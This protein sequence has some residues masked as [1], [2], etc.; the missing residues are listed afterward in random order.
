MA[1]KKTNRIKKS[2]IDVALRLLLTGSLG[3]ALVAGNIACNQYSNIITQYLCG[4]GLNTDTEEAKAA[5]DSGNTLA[6]QVEA[7]GAVMLK[8]DGTLPLQKNKVNV[9]GWAGCDSGFITQGTGSGTGSRNDRVTL[10]GGLKE[11]G[12]SYNTDLTQKYE[13]LGYNRVTGGNY[14][15]EAYSDALY[16]QYYGVIEAPN[17]FY[18][19]E[20]MQSAKSYSDTAIVVIGRLMGE[21]NDYSKTQYIQNEEND[22]SRKL[23]ALS[24]REEYMLERVCKYFDNVVV[25]INSG[26]PMEAGFLENEKIGAGIFMGYPG[27]RGPIGVAKILTGE[28]NPSGHLSDTWAYDLSTAAS[29]ANAGREGTGSYTDI[30]GDTSL[31]TRANKY[32]DYAE[33]IYIGYKWYETADAEGFWDSSYAKQRWGILDG[34]DSVV[35]YPF[36]YGKSYTTFEW[37]ITDANVT[38]GMTVAKDGKIELTVAVKNT[39]SVAGK[40]VVQLYYSAP[41]TKGGIE[42]SAVNLG[43]FAKTAL[44]KPGEYESVKISL[45]VEDMKSYD[46]YDRNNNGFMGYEL[47]KGEYTISL[48]TDSH[49]LATTG[50][51]DGRNSY[52]VQV[53]DDIRYETDSTTGNKVENRFTNYTNAVSG[54]SSTIQEYAVSDAHSIDGND[55]DVKI[56]YMTRGDFTGTFPEEKIATRTA[57]QLKTDAFY[58]TPESKLSKNPDDVAPTFNS[59]ETSWTLTDVMGLDYEDEKWDELVSQLS[60]DTMASLIVHGGFGTISIPSIG[61]PS[62]VDADG[63]SGFNNAVTG[64][65]NLKAVNYPCDTIIGSTWD[66]YM[67]YQVGRAIGIEA[68]A[69]GLNGIYGPGNNLHRSAMGGRNFEYYSEDA[70]LSGI[71]CAYEVYGMKEQG[72]TA[73]VKHIAAN[74]TESGRNGAFKW[75]T[76]QSMRENYLKAFEILVKVGKSNA[77]M[78]SVDRVGSTRAS[79]SWAMLTGIMRNE[80]GFRG[81]V[82]T[83]YY[84]NAGKSRETDTIHDVDEC[85]RAGNSQLLWT[86]GGIGFFNDA[87]SAT[88]KK[89]I[90]K[91]AKDILFAYVDTKNFAATAQGLE[92]DSMIGESVEVFAW[93]KPV[94]LG[95]DVVGGL[96]I[97]LSVVTAFKPKKVKEKKVKKAAKKD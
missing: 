85:V 35:Q 63:P 55:E 24:Q 13:A 25:L 96:L 56:K 68:D 60:L 28:V 20:L 34:Y 33:D 90:F 46:C 77:M 88:A 16:K 53:S 22:A 32:N 76:E 70:V 71:M 94:L 57:G 15:I 69:I 30:S 43:A 61:K 8:N 54:A 89:A 75:L 72:L 79:S 91:S 21:G 73:Y 84:Q 52:T 97:L 14:V 78:T 47:E 41:Y 59:T 86:D 58:V 48:R 7:E 65:G 1:K 92:K 23:Q 18:S 10:L 3:F 5:R 38:D 82:I 42:K 9:F 11:V 93:W 83:D 81:T 66:W 40:D 95:V 12:L 37:T 4:F 26:N 50:N 44:L 27:T 64:Q 49:T 2:P 45:P 80:W 74:D 67:A 36:G 51:G 19:D 31:G 6:A 39:G 62:T 87:D 29:Y 17:D